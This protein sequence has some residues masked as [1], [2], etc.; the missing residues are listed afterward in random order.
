MSQSCFVKKHVFFFVCVL[1]SQAV[2][3]ENII[4]SEKIICFVF[5]LYDIVLYC[6]LGQTRSSVLCNKETNL[7]A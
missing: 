6:L 3:R 2:T 4:I 7:K 1:N 5:F